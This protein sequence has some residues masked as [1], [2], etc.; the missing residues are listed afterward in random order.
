MID[1]AAV[2]LSE[3]VTNVVQHGEPEI[4]VRLRLDGNCIAVAV[5]YLGEAPLPP[6][7]PVPPTDQPHGRGLLIVDALATR[8]GVSRHAG[9]AGKT[10][11]FELVS[12]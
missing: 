6:V 2:M 9:K 12:T 11:W 3:L 10:V 7:S 8:W 4:T 1:D 5:A